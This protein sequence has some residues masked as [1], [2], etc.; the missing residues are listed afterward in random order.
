MNF[1]ETSLSTKSISIDYQFNLNFRWTHTFWISNTV[2]W[3]TT[4]FPI[5][6]LSQRAVIRNFGS[7]FV[8]N[9]NKLFHKWSKCRWL[10]TPWSS[11]N[12]TIMKLSVWRSH[13]VALWRKTMCI[14]LLLANIMTQRFGWK[15]HNRLLIKFWGQISQSYNKSQKYIRD[16]C[17]VVF[18]CGL[19]LTDFSRIHHD[20]F[21]GSKDILRLTHWHWSNN[22]EYG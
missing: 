22:D 3:E 16:L 2:C 11:C 5:W 6:F 4:Y 9:V 12:I 8:V 20:Y 10:E 18:G 13:T 15:V 1:V 7:C 19:A 21:I 14:N 17:S